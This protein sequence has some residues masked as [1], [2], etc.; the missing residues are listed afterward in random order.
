MHDLAEQQTVN[1]TT[2]VYTEQFVEIEPHAKE[3][4]RNGSGH[5]YSPKKY[6]EWKKRF[7]ALV[8]PFHMVIEKNIGIDVIY[9]TRTG[10]MRPD[11]DNAIGAV[12][13]A[14]QQAN[15]LGNDRDVKYET[16][17]VLP[18]KQSGI[19]FKIYKR[20][21]HIVP[22]MLVPMLKVLKD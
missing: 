11:L 4:P 12:W 2:M 14:L 9:L 21:N 19:Y 22:D 6:E 17:M 18:G 16:S 5:M 8:K 20:T 13:D 10:D 3:R 1:A 15:Y 7:A